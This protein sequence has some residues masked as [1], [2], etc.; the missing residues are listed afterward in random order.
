[1]QGANPRMCIL[2]STR[3]DAYGAGL[4]TAAPSF[5]KLGVVVL[6][7]NCFSLPFAQRTVSLYQCNGRGTGG[8][9][10]VPYIQSQRG[11]RGSL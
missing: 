2:S 9:H 1:M 10:P 4:L 8:I 11:V 7:R 3:G 5:W 6:S